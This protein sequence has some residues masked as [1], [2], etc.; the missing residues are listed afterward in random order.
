MTSPDSFCHL[1]NGVVG[2]K[3]IA[4]CYCFLWL[5]HF[6][7]S[8][9]QYIGTFFINPYL[10]KFAPNICPAVYTIPVKGHIYTVVHSKLL[11]VREIWTISGEMI[12][13]LTKLSASRWKMK[14]QRY[15]DQ[16]GLGKNVLIALCGS[17]IAIKKKSEKSTAAQLPNIEPQDAIN[18]SLLSWNIFR[19]F[20]FGGY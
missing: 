1:L 12:G 7:A 11:I 5:R 9:I 20:S 2:D 18:H 10:V 3:K 17:F 13:V 15:I 14:K 4:E 16:S 8:E 6:L 19:L